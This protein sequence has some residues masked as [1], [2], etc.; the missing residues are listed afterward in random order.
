MA[1]RV[2]SLA[3]EAPDETTRREMERMADKMDKM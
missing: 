2:R 3:A 1:D